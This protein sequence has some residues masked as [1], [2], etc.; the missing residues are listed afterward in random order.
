MASKLAASLCVVSLRHFIHCQLTY[1]NVS[2]GSLDAKLRQLKRL[3][4]DEVHAVAV[5]LMSALKHM[6][7]RAF[8]HR[9][10]KPANILCFEGGRVALCDLGFAGRVPS[11][12]DAEYEIMG[13]YAC[14]APELLDVQPYGY[15]VSPSPH[16]F[17]SSL[18]LE[19]PDLFLRQSTCS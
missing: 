7:A 17:F 14:M 5:Q 15:P 10:I 19:L 8:I 3:P 6:H 9:D 13:T 4:L 1:L 16:A 11:P 18:S 2:A 12:E